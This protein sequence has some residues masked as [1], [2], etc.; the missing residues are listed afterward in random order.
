M[1]RQTKSPSKVRSGSDTYKRGVPSGAFRD[2][3][4][5]QVNPKTEQFAPSEKEP[6]RSRYRMG[7]GC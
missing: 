5:V 7:G 1:A 4:L 3:N 6:V 2:R